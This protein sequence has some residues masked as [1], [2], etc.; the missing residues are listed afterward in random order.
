MHNGKQCSDV[1][2]RVSIMEDNDTGWPAQPPHWAGCVRVQ[3]WIIKNDKFP[4]A[5]SGV[6]LVEAAVGGNSLEWAFYCWLSWCIRDKLFQSP[7]LRSLSAL[8]VCSV[9]RYNDSA[10]LWFIQRE[11][12]KKKRCIVKPLQTCEVSLSSIRALLCTCDTFQ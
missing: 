10:G 11:S 2:D 6:L 9:E 7:C 3:G 1:W 5:I 12:V 8:P 4:N